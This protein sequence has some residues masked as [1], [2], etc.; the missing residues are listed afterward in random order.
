MATQEINIYGAK[1]TKVTVTPSLTTGTKIADI[2]VNGSNKELYAPKGGSSKYQDSSGVADMIITPWTEYDKN[3]NPEIIPIYNDS[4]SSV[5]GLH[6]SL[7]TISI[8]TYEESYGYLHFVPKVISLR[9][10]T[11]AYNHIYIPIAFNENGIHR[12]S[13][14]TKLSDISFYTS[15]TATIPDT[16]I[17]NSTTVT[18]LLSVN[19]SITTSSNFTI[20]DG[21]DVTA[22]TFSIETLYN[23][24]MVII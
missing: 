3:V 5:K 7:G 9:Y 14:T 19:F 8:G 22:S 18:A 11:P 4:V 13:S 16:F 20:E 12:A 17:Y 6:I 23:D 21:F 1:P 24:G 10:S 2:S 15:F